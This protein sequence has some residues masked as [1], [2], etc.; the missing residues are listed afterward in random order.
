MAG[1]LVIIPIGATLVVLRIVFEWAD[2]FG[3]PF[4]RRF[5]HIDFPGLGILLTIF[6]VYLAG[7]FT[8]N[9]IGKRIVSL[10]EGSIVKRVPIVRD[11]YGALKKLMGAFSLAGKGSFKRVVLIEFPRPGVKSMGFVTGETR[12]PASGNRLVNV[13]IPTVPNPTSGLLQLVDEA[14]ITATDISVEE[15][16]QVIVSGG[17]LNAEKLLSR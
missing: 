2:G 12:D 6:L 5:F 7:L 11:L 1:I 9:V 4:I 3:S 16:M 15:G 10:M 8:T 17:F 14:E 13:F